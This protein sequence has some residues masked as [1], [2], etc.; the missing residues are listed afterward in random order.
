MEDFLRPTSENSNTIFNNQM[1]VVM[2]MMEMGEWM[3][4]GG[5]AGGRW[6][7]GLGISGGRKKQENIEGLG[8]WRNVFGRGYFF[9]AGKWGDFDGGEN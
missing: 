3:A 5:Y 7:R 6:R 4:A 9:F 2:G 1:M 8:R